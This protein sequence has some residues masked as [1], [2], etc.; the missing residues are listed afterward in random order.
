[1]DQNGH[2][3]TRQAV[4]TKDITRNDVQKVYPWLTNSVKSGFDTT[5][6]INDQ[7][8]H[9]V[10]RLIHRYSNQANGEGSYV[11]YY[12]NPISVYSE[13]QNENGTTFYYDSRTG[14]KKTGWVNIN[15]NNQ[16]G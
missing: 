6:S 7:I 12:S 2:E 5:V 10:V 1:M 15:N 8:N 4:N 16:F 11:D 3:L 13:F 9:K 14:A